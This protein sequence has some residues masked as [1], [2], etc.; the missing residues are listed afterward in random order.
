MVDF[1]E[2]KMVV[3]ARTYDEQGKSKTEAMLFYQRG[4]LPANDLVWGMNPT[5]Y[6]NEWKEGYNYTTSIPIFFIGEAEEHSKK[7][8]YMRFTQN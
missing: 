5:E 3:K 6:F 2:D 7:I 1:V 4:V 8:V